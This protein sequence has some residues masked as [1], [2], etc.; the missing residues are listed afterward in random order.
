MPYRKLFSALMLLAC[1]GVTSASLADSGNLTVVGAGGVLQDAERKAFFEP[2]AKSSG[3]SVTEDSYSGQMAKVRAMVASG[4]VSWDVM[5]VEQ[6]TLLSG[7]AEG[8]FE[9]LDWT[10]IGHQE[11]FIPEAYNECGV[12]AFVWSMVPSYDKSKL[13]E[14]PT[15][16]ADF[17]DI[18]KWP[19]KRGFRQ[20][21][22]MTLEI[23]LLADGVPATEVY[24]VLSTKG[25]QDRA[26]A[27][28]DQ[29]KPDII[30]WTS[31]AESL[32]RL[33][34]GDVVATATF[35][36]R[37]S[38]ANATGKNFAL[39]WDGQVY[40]IDYWAIVKGSANRE[41]AEKFIAFAS[42]D[43]AQS[44]FPQY[45]A[46][47]VTNKKA[48]SSVKPELAKDLPTTEEN[49]KTAV[50]LNTEFW[51]DNGEALEAR[52]ATWRAQ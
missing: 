3:V 30:W 28:L 37:V 47:G 24:D 25:G 27:K 43:A 13:A 36:G 45:M 22:K 10:R 44:V 39:I 5:Q 32:E 18:Q 29:I 17:W 2:F 33:A 40:G 7:C 34:S 50:G 51:A 12:G 52:F 20:T 41:N 23:A 8:L 4:S 6:N 31:G 49:L 46:Y 38:A 14:G 15:N 35:N 11:D 48:I 21:A 1:L 9:E 42:S 26:F 19:G 16:W